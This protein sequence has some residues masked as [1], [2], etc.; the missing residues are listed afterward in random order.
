[1]N[2]LRTAILISGNGGNLQALIN[3]SKADSNYP[4]EILLVISNKPEAYGLIRAQKAGI[5]TLVINHKDY[6]TREEFDNEI[7]KHLTQN[8]IDIVC[9]AGF[10]RILTADFVNK[11]AGR[12]I[13]IHPSLLPEFKGAHAVRDALAAGAKTTGCTVHLVTPE[14]DSGKI[15]IQRPVDISP[16]DTEETLSEKIHTQE[17]LASPEALKKLCLYLKG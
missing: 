4:A 1:M 10:M 13:N 11:W 5:K 14:I 8:K 3:A 12:M 17:H 15:L 9:L 16:E 6:K 7:H 2:K